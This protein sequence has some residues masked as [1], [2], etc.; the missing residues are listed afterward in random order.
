MVLPRRFRTSCGQSPIYNKATNLNW[1]LCPVELVLYSH[2][3]IIQ[4]N[5][6]VR[7]YTK[8]NQE[9]SFGQNNERVN[10][11]CMNCTKIWCTI[12][13]MWFVNFKVEWFLYSSCLSGKLWSQPE[14]RHS[15]LSSAVQ[16]HCEFAKHDTFN[17]CCMH[18]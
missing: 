7:R 1:N 13:K 6:N 4:F 8:I 15:N 10:R 18:A 12:Y 3:T 11:V 14:H 17:L 16:T 9:I 5:E 2:K